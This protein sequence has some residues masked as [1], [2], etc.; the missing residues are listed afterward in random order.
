MAGS[1]PLRAAIFSIV[2]RHSEAQLLAFCVNQR[3]HFDASAWGSV[4]AVT[5]SELAATACYLAGVAWYGHQAQ[6]RKIAARLS[7]KA[8][9]DLVRETDFDPSRFGGLLRA[10]L[11]HAEQA[12]AP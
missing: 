11:Q 10:H 12:V 9:A 7:S 5:R 8:F 3:S 1:I 2:N 4:S 6:L